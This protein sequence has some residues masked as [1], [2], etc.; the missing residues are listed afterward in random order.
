MKILTSIQ[1]IFS[2]LS[3]SMLYSPPKSGFCTGA[4]HRCKCYFKGPQPWRIALHSLGPLF[5]RARLQPCDEFPIMQSSR[6]KPGILTTSFP[7]IWRGQHDLINA[8]PAILSEHEGVHKVI[9]GEEEF[10]PQLEQE[11]DQLKLQDKITLTGFQ[12]E[13]RIA[14]WLN[15]SDIFV[16]PSL[17]EGTRTRS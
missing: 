1:A 12:V 13:E 4:Q 7:R 2:I 11:I 14:K 15:A 9:I 8:L 10:R 16:F 3:S 17:R 6:P 5:C